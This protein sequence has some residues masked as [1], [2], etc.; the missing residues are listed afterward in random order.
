MDV[1]A[2]EEAVAAPTTAAPSVGGASTCSASA[3]TA[4]R[5]P[6]SSMSARAVGGAGA[7][8]APAPTADSRLP[9][10]AA[11]DK[12][13][14]K[15]HA[16]AG[17]SARD[18]EP[19]GSHPTAAAHND[20]DKSA[21]SGA[22]VLAAARLV[23]DPACGAAASTS[24]LSLLE[25]LRLPTSHILKLLHDHFHLRPIKDTGWLA[26]TASTWRVQLRS[27]RGIKAFVAAMNTRESIPLPTV[28][29]QGAVV[30]VL[31]VGVFA[32]SADGSFSEP[33]TAA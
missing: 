24:M 31:V 26:S 4:A 27:D 29:Y 14:A 3:P 32:R 18:G 5:P 25:W 16:E 9:A 21:G 11:K 13:H 12:L 2:R 19:T 28:V 23:I 8:A 1:E 7:T 30:R 33:V 10:R 20:K 15:V 22:G 17:A 6:A